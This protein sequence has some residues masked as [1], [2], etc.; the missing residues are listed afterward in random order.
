MAKSLGTRRNGLVPPPRLTPAVEGAALAARL[1]AALE[2]IAAELERIRL[3]LERKSGASPRTDAH[4][5]TGPWL[6]EGRDGG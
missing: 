1:A 5:E 3:A 2:G 6:R 4:A